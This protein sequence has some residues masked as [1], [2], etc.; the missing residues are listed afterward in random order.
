MC[1][2]TWWS[3]FSCVHI[4]NIHNCKHNISFL[5]RLHF[6]IYSVNMSAVSNRLMHYFL[7]FIFFFVYV[8]LFISWKPQ[9]KI[10]YLYLYMF[11]IIFFFGFCIV[12]HNS[13]KWLLYLLFEEFLCFDNSY[14]SDSLMPIYGEFST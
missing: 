12:S 5:M 11:L 6:E 9:K 14:K 1:N 13:K 2:L 10:C 8:F 7:F 4:W 3:M